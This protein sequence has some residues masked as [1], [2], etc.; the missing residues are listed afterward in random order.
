MLFNTLIFGQEH[1]GKSAVFA[2]VANRPLP[3]NYTPTLG[4]DYSSA[5]RGNAVLVLRDTA[6]QERFK[7]IIRSYYKTAAIGV[8]CFDLSKTYSEYA[9]QAICQEIGLFKQL[10][11]SSAL[12]LVG[13]KSDIMCQ[14]G[15]QALVSLTNKLQAQQIRYTQ[16]TD[17]AATDNPNPDKLTNTLFQITQEQWKKHKQSFLSQ[18]LNALQQEISYLPQKLRS[19]IV[20]KATA[21]LGDLNDQQQSIQHKEQAI[22]RFITTSSTLLAN[23]PIAAK[24]VT[25]FAAVA[26]ITFLAF[27]MGFGIGFVAGAWTGPGAFFSA[28][29]S[30]SLAASVVASSAIAGTISTYMF[31]KRHPQSTRPAIANFAKQ[32]Q[33]AAHTPDVITQLDPSFVRSHVGWDLAQQRAF[34]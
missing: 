10:A 15:I 12:V 26:L 29:A 5:R 28:L 11:A 25:K 19:S 1:S 22:N 13:T 23:H 20:D 7:T 4:V 33:E 18:S 24:A 27:V 32:C 14:E 30:S 3:N 31:F 34:S 8:Y 9:I 17:T 2:R 6:G 16:I 21:L